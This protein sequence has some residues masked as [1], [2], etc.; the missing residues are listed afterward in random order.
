MKDNKSPRSGFTL[1]ELLTV[2]A[3]IGILA[4]ILI[5]A[6]GKVREVANKTKSSSNIRSI[7]ISYATY[8]TSGG[9]V[10]TLNSSRLTAA[11][12]DDSIYGVGSFLA[13][14]VDL[15]DASIWIIGSD[16]AVA[17]YA[18]D[19]P[20]VVGFRNDQNVYEDAPEWVSGVPVGYDFAVGV[21]GNAPTSTT[22]LTWT[23]GLDLT[24]GTWGKDTP[25]GLGG[26]IAY[27][28][29]HVQ[30]YTELGTEDGQL[31]NPTTGRLTVAM[32][33]IHTSDNVKTAPV[34]AP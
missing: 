29:G 7:A 1:I 30:F 2:I 31:V 10:R 12:F 33:D 25:W 15:T 13:K 28:D 34:F 22:P 16:P 24:N 32:S 14:Q 20:A 19:L 23:R 18:A 8:S 9:K 26:H 6:V 11:G 3:I 5:P 21:S 4:A 17:D 27:L